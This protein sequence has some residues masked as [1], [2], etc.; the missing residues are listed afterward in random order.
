VDSYEATTGIN[1]ALQEKWSVQVAMGGRRTE[2]TYD[3]VRLASYYGLFDYYQ[4]EMVTKTGWGYVGQAS[5]NYNGE[6]TSGS[7]TASRD[8]A[9]ASGQNGTVERTSFTLSASRRLSYE[10]RGLFSTSYFINKSS[11]GEI[12]VAPI[13]Y[14]TLNITPG[15]RYEFNKDMFLEGSYTY[16]R[17]ENKQ[18]GTTADRDLFLIRFFVQHAVLE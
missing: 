14:Q 16:T 4:Q 10:F 9:P 15:I 17:Y 3:T 13:N 11:G 12:L 1:Y 2:S 5:L 7:F 8:L 6:V 18:A